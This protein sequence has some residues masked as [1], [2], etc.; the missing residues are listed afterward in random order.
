MSAFGVASVTRS[1][2]VQLVGEVGGLERPG[3]VRAVDMEGGGAQSGSGHEIDRDVE[4]AGLDLV[5]GYVLGASP[6]SVTCTLGLPVSGSAL[7]TKNLTFVPR[8]NGAAT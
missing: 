5:A 6:G 8:V 4:A 2:S 7:K 1:G 3:G